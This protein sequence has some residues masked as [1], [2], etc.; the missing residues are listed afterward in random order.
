M[1]AGGD[2]A[3]LD[4]LAQG[5]VHIIEIPV[6]LFGEMEV[7]LAE[8][9]RLNTLDNSG[10]QRSWGRYAVIARRWEFLEPMMALCRLKKIPVRLMR[11]NQG[12]ELHKTREGNRVQDA[13]P[14]ECN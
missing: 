13:L 11:D 2:F 7:A 10:M 9:L 3:K 12:P 14:F 5:R 1:P 8:L 6:T 4:P